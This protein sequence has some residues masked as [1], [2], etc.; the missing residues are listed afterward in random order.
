MNWFYAI[1]SQKNG[2]VTDT[3]LDELLLSG[4]IN[5]QTL[6]WRE[7]MDNWQPLIQI[8]PGGAGATGGQRTGQACVEC[9]RFFPPDEL[10]R[11][12]QSPVCAA[13]KPI[14]LQRRSEGLALPSSVGLWRKKKRI[15]TVS[16]TVFPDRCIKCNEPANGFRLK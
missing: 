8:R 2:P 15:V 13:C 12:Q 4:K 16:E 11:I 6:V 3:Q 10:I 7:G 9:G 14:F 5:Q 1:D